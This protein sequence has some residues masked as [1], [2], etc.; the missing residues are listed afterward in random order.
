MSSKAIY[1]LLVSAAALGSVGAHA[2]NAVWG[3]D[4]LAKTPANTS[5]TT[6]AQVKSELLQ[7]QRQGF[8]ATGNDNSYPATPM[9][10]V[11]SRA[12]VRNELV[13]ARAE[14][15]LIIYQH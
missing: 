8:G 5:T 12:E 1:A 7:A 14:G 15:P 11:K 3:L 4:Y 2:D 6:R 13:Q 10:S 9:A